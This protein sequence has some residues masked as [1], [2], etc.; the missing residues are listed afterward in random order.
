MKTFFLK[1][2]SYLL[3]K[4]NISVFGK[5]VPSKETKLS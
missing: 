1:N 4:I 3:K 5:I 2:K